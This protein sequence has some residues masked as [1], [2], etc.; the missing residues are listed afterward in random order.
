MPFGKHKGRYV[1]D[2]P[3]DYLVWLTKNVELKPTLKWA[4]EEAIDQKYR[5]YTPPPPPPPAR[6]HVRMIYRDLALR[7]HPDRGGSTTAMQAINEFY[8]RLRGLANER[9]TGAAHH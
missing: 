5:A 1:Y 9:K 4:V 2:L 3:I 7:Y 8:E 6:D